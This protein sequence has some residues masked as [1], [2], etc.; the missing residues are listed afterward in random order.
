[1]KN[2]RRKN[3]REDKRRSQRKVK[4]NVGEEKREKDKR[5]KVSRYTQPTTM[6]EGNRCVTTQITNMW[7][8][9]S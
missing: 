9:E 5:K 8:L 3:R 4:E 6:R 2:P 1:M 7:Q